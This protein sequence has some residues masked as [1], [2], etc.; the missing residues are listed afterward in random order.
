MDL[1]LPGLTET[2]GVRQKD[3]SVG[4]KNYLVDGVSGAG[5]TW[6]AEELQRR[7]CHVLHGDRKLKYQGDPETG[8]G[9]KNLSMKARVTRPY[10]DKGTSFGMWIKLNP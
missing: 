6:V 4:K 5:K 3:G 10:G 7:G 1:A 9:S 8:N 2:Q